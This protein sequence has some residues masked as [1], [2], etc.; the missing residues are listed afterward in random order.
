MEYAACHTD[1]IDGEQLSLAAGCSFLILAQQENHDKEAGCG[2]G[3]G[4]QNAEDSGE[5]KAGEQDARG[6]EEQGRAPIQPIES[7]NNDEIRQPQ[8]HARET[9]QER[10]ECLQPGQCQR[11]RREH[12]SYRQALC[13]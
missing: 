3:D 9:R 10:K 11:Q 5:E 6:V 4:I 1:T 12:S 2:T 7:E 13:K 8:L